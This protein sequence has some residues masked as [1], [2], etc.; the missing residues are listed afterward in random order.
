MHKG[1]LFLMLH[2]HLPYV[3]HPEYEDFL[4][5]DW[6]YEA[7]T[8]TYIPLLQ[9]FEGAVQDGIDFRVTMSLTPSL[10]SMMTDPLLQERY[11]RHISKLIELAG[12]EVE[13]T[14]WLPEFHSLAQMYYYRLSEI[15][16][17]FQDRKGRN[18]CPPCYVKYQALTESVAGADDDDVHDHDDDDHDHDEDE[19]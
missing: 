3:R 18:L 13:R 8:E 11:Y 4:E 6:F 5:E 9:V 10:I 19:D 16:D 14:R 15:R 1:Y 2:A 7:M 17:Y 12:R